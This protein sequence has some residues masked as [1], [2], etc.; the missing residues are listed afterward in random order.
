MSF[1]ARAMKAK[2]NKRGYIHWKSF[3]TAKETINKWKKPPT[4]WEKIFEKNISDKEGIDIQNKV[5]IHTYQF[6]FWLFLLSLIV[7]IGMWQTI[8]WGYSNFLFSFSITAAA[9]SLQ[10]SLTL[11]GP[12]EGSL[13]RSPV[14]EILQAR[15]LEWVAVS[16]SYISIFK[17]LFS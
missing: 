9:K 13:P 11:W 3:C 4:E 6:F 8:F 17:N 5:Y 10:S 12:I 2:I 16:F 15:T 7:L 1:Q 14:P